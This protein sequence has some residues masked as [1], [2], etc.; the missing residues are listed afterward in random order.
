MFV[1]NKGS[2]GGAQL[3]ECF[4]STLEALGLIPNTALTR[5]VVGSCNP[6][7]GEGQLEEV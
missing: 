4:L 6:S 2:R 5:V 7:T 3:V 1:C